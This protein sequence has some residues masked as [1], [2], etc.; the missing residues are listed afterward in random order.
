MSD[1]DY[2]IKYSKYK[3]KYFEYRLLGGKNMPEDFPKQ[4]VYE[5]SIEPIWKNIIANRINDFIND[6]SIKN[7]NDI[8]RLNNFI[9][10]FNSEYSHESVIRSLR[11]CIFNL[12]SKILQEEL[13]NIYKSIIN[14]IDNLF[15]ELNKLDNDCKGCVMNT[16]YTEYD[17]GRI[18][19]K[20]VYI[21]E[22]KVDDFSKGNNYLDSIGK[23]LCPYS[24]LIID[25]DKIFYFNKGFILSEI[26]KNI[27][28]D[29]IK[30]VNIS[31]NNSM[32]QILLNLNRDL[33]YNKDLIFYEITKKDTSDI[34]NKKLNDVLKISYYLIGK[35]FGVISNQLHYR[36]NKNFF[37]DDNSTKDLDP[38]EKFLLYGG[39]IKLEN[40]GDKLY[41]SIWEGFRQMALSH[42]AHGMSSAELVARIA[43][44]VRTSYPLA[45][46]SALCVRSGAY[47]GGAM[48]KAI[49]MIKEYLDKFTNECKKGSTSNENI[50]ISE[51]IKEEIFNYIKELSKKTMYGFGH[52]IHKSPD[53]DK[54]CADPRALEYLEIVHNIYK[55]DKS[56]EIKLIDLFLD[57]V[58]R[59]N[60]KLGC[61]SDFVIAVFCI[62]TEVPMDDAE[63]MFVMCRIPGFCARI[64]RELLGKAN[65]RRLPFA[66]ILPY[67][68]PENIINKCNK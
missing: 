27:I 11:D 58:K 14:Q 16:P 29:N 19:N 42:I 5:N 17:I 6:N 3:K 2:R 10:R 1:L 31:V 20:K 21:L 67:I 40:K 9:D 54:Q 61:N 7:K 4:D 25:E 33:D 60:S 22:Q 56:L 47:H 18:A 36:R 55:E 8:D 57:S 30:C 65:A 15:I 37:E 53:S 49:P 24:N 63:G 39:I 13:D 23:L 45:L 34:I 41:D 50:D 38:I 35:L 52:R 44:S 68:L 32:L 48:Q 43:S 62:L 51:E 26:D 12:E 59:I 66:P 46:I 64:V 28:R